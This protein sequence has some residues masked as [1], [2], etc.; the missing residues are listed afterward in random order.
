MTITLEYLSEK[1]NEKIIEAIKN[2]EYHKAY[3]LSKALTNTILALR[4]DQIS[5]VDDD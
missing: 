2:K 4:S 3:R 1:I 5:K